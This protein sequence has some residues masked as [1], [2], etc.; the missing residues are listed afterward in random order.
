MLVLGAEN[1]T[2]VPVVT[3][4]DGYGLPVFAEYSFDELR[5][6]TNGFA[7]DRIVSESG[8]KAPNVVYRGT[9]SSSGRSVAIKRLARFAW[10]DSRQFLVYVASFLPWIIPY[11]SVPFLL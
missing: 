2:G 6:A 8:E 7:Y 4:D 1:G 11:M 10:P 9:L 5:A 3:E